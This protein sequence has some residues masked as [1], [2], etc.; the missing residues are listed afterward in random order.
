MAWCDP[1]VLRLEQSFSANHPTPPTTLQP[2]NPTTLRQY[3]MQS[4][5]A[6][7]WLHTN[8]VAVHSRRCAKEQGRAPTLP[9]M[10]WKP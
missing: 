3:T 5:P 7:L 1:D 4:W 6:V 8:A 2:Y 10:R 9:S